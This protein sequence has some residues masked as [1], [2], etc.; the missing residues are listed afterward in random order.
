M[1]DVNLANKQEVTD[2]ANKAGSITQRPQLIKMAELSLRLESID[3]MMVQLRQIVQSKQGDI[4]D[5]QDDRSSDN[6]RHRWATLGRRYRVRFWTRLWL[7][8]LSWV[9]WRVKG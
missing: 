9:G 1:G 3:K 4:Y 6:E 7:K 5:F 2:R 8:L